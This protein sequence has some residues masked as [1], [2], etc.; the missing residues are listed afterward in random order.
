MCPPG[1]ARRAAPPPQVAALAAALPASEGPTGAA[2]DRAPTAPALA[3]PRA[4]EAPPPLS[5]PVE[6][7]EELALAQAEYDAA[8]SHYTSLVT[9]GAEGN[10]EEALARYKAAYPHLEALKALKAARGMQ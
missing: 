10:V 6:A 4:G 1:P 2:S 7:D 8:F 5:Q 9:T 3:A